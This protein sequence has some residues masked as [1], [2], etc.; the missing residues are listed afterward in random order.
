MTQKFEFH[1]YF[2]SC[3]ICIL[4]SSAPQIVN[5]DVIGSTDSPPEFRIS[6]ITKSFTVDE[7]SSFD[8]NVG[9]VVAHDP[10]PGNFKASLNC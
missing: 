8:T 3:A 2:I 9:T 4:P 10:D 1:Y 6:E 5:V 7:G